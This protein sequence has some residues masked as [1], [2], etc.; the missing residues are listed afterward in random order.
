MSDKFVTCYSH[1]DTA[2]DI[3]NRLIDARKH[4]KASA[5]KR[6]FYIA[7]EFAEESS[8]D[9]EGRMV[10]T[11]STTLSYRDV[12]IVLEKDNHSPVYVARIEREIGAPCLP[13]YNQNLVKEGK[14]LTIDEVKKRLDKM[15]R[16]ASKE[17]KDLREL[18]VEVTIA[19]SPETEGAI[20]AL[21]FLYNNGIGRKFYDICQTLFWKIVER[22]RDRLFYI[23]RHPKQTSLHICHNEALL[24]EI[25]TLEWAIGENPFMPL[26][27]N[28]GGYNGFSRF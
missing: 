19:P 21:E 12:D 28:G 8:M 16:R 1:P 6:S 14:V 10:D 9:I 15:R 13:A 20:D 7:R 22:E 18:G 25:K 5:I 11:A 3:L 26:A 24:E 27:I 23:R 2:Y 17:Q 4:D